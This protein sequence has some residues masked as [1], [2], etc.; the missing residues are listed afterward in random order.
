VKKALGVAGRCGIPPAEMQT[1]RLSIEPR[2]KDDYRKE[3]FLGFF[4]RN[5]VVL[6][7]KDP[8]RVEE[9]VTKL[10]EAG[11]NTIHDVDFQTT[12][13]KKHRE[14]ARVLALQAAREKAE[15]MAAV[16]GQAVGAPLAISET[17]A[18]SPWSSYSSWGYG[19]WGYGRD[20]GISQNVAQNAG[21]DPGEA[22]GGIALGKIAVRASVSVTF[23]LIPR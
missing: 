16:Y 20:R 13:Y 17:Y 1:D 15:K 2:Y 8:A 11:V 10:L 19:G 9:L 23:A 7:L 5:T 4:V 21:G 18:G 22:A 3:N 6:T 14:Q 12:E